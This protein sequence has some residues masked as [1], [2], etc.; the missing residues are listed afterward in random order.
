[1]NICIRLRRRNDKQLYQDKQ[2]LKEAVATRL[3]RR[4]PTSNWNSKESGPGAPQRGPRAVSHART[5][6]STR[7]FRLRAASAGRALDSSPGAKKWLCPRTFGLG[8]ASTVGARH[9]NAGF[10]TAFREL[11]R[12]GATWLGGRQRAIGSSDR[13]SDQRAPTSKAREGAPEAGLSFVS[14]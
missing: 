2:I 7:S 3:G 14:P 6:A 10:P 8:A 1:M 11:S 9:H 4:G 5:A 12:I 13:K